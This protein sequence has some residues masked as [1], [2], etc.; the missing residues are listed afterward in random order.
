M[1]RVSVLN[2][3]G[4]TQI[5]SILARHLRMG[6]VILLEGEMG[7]GKSVFTRALARNLGIDEPIPSPTFTIL[8]LHKGPELMLAHL[9]LYR[10]TNEDEFY[11]MGLEEQ[12]PPED[13]IA[14]IEWP[15][16]CPDAM[17][18]KR[19][20]IEIDRVP[21]NEQGR[22]VSLSFSE[23]DRETV[24]RDDLLKSGLTVA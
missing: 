18:S 1:L 24:V 9:D 13:G 23:T 3:E 5:A 6:D 14:V 12:V 2:E 19:I 21:G 4:T 17:P 8:L 7:T 22:T 16:N 11:E 20:M 10:L 15:S